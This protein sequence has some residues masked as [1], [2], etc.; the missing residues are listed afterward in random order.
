MRVMPMTEAP[1]S[2]IQVRRATSEDA[3][4]C[5]AIVDDWITRTDWMPRDATL[6][7][8]EAGIAN[9]MSLREIWVAGDPVEGYLSLDPDS[10]K[11]GGFYCSRTGEGLGRAL[12][13]RVKEGRDYLWLHTHVPNEAAQRFYR[14]EGFI[15]LAR[16]PAEP[17]G[18]VDEVQME[19]RG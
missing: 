14:R 10:L 2:E 3:P 9:A 17:P 1:T 19:W 6:E 8:L 11:I 13:D 4:A 18:T 15:E 7:E 5:A 16:V 12:M